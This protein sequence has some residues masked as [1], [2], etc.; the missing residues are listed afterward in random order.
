VKKNE[1]R[2]VLNPVR[3]LTHISQQPTRLRDFITYKVMH[4]IKNFLSYENVIK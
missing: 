2:D 1:N 3:K 4:Q